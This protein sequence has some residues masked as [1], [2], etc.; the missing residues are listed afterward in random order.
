MRE[1]IKD[2]KILMSICC[3]HVSEPVTLGF[4]DDLGY[5]DLSDCKCEDDNGEFE[6]IKPHVFVFFEGIN[7][8]HNFRLILR[9]SVFI[10]FGKYTFLS[11]ILD[12]GCPVAMML[13]RDALARLKD[14][15]Q[16]NSNSPYKIRIK[17]KVFQVIPIKD[18]HEPA[19]I[20]GLPVIRKFG[21]DI[22]KNNFRLHGFPTCLNLPEGTACSLIPEDES[23]GVADMLKKANK[24]VE[25]IKKK[26]Q[27]EVSEM[28]K[29]AEEE[30]AQMRKIAVE[31][32]EEMRREAE[33]E[34]VV[35]KGTSLK[36]QFAW[37]TK[38]KPVSSTKPKSIS[39]TKSKSVSLTR[40]KSVSSTKPK[41]VSSTSSLISLKK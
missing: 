11:F 37:S 28:K 6:E 16:V 14:A 10:S 12:T 34:I 2:L 30:I 7:V 33:K 3:F 41:F 21:M 20:I 35:E 29:T 4:S 18:S 8:L 17:D 24:D 26:A 13:S 23:I 38:P 22:S 31:E 19:N 32:I 40:P 5:A 15:L 9:I 27:E 25:T 39:S 1:R 36:S